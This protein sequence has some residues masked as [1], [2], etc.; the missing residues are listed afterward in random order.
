[1]KILILILFVLS[2]S[3]CENVKTD[4]SYSNSQSYY[5]EDGTLKDEFYGKGENSDIPNSFEA[6]EVDKNGKETGKGGSTHFEFV[7]EEVGINFQIYESSEIALKQLNQ[8]IEKAD[9]VIRKSVIKNNKGEEVGQKALLIQ[10]TETEG[11]R[12]YSLVWTRNSRLASLSGD[13]LKAIE[14]YENDRKL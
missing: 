3:G 10:T 4:E 13:S 9:K 12:Y 1:M 7:N 11:R 2:L 14:A 8:T 6:V 5:R